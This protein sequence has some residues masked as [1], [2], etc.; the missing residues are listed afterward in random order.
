[1]RNWISILAVVAGCTASADDE[2]TNQSALHVLLH[3]APANVNEVWVDITRVEALNADTGWLTVSDTPQTVDLLSLQDG[4]FADLGLANL[5]AGHY[6]QL[7]IEV[8]DSWVVDS[9]G[10]HPLEVPSGDES[11]IKII[12]GFDVL[13]CGTTTM[14]LDWDVGAHLGENSNGF[15][16]R[17]VIAVE[18]VAVEGCAT[19][20]RYWRV[21]IA[22]V[23]STQGLSAVLTEVEM[24]WGGQTHVLSSVGATVAPINFWGGTGLTS[25]IDGSLDQSTGCFA[26][27]YAY[28]IPGSALDFDLQSPQS[29]DAVLI[30]QGGF[31]EA[32]GLEWTISEL[33]IYSSNDGATY[34]LARGFTG[35]ER[36]DWQAQTLKTFPLQ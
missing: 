14:T 22:A 6:N 24:Q 21:E 26:C 7:R 1:M 17:P 32:S 8:G 29:V 31:R 15:V 2:S 3:D 36:S 28:G 19:T 35:I 34:S 25:L 4:V 30:S 33:N 23:D 12:R 20:A 11:G 5:P 27:T 18:S 10:T 13:E 9:S 16:L